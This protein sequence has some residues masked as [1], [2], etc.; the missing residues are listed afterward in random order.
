[1]TNRKGTWPYITE[2]I[3]QEDRGFL[4]PCWV[5]TGGLNEKGYGCARFRDFDSTRVHRVVYELKV[6]PI[7]DGLVIDHLCR[8]RACC[9][10]SHL[11]VVTTAENNRRALAYRPPG[12]RWGGSPK[13]SHCMSGHPLSGDN[14]YVS[15]K[16][17]RRCRACQG[18]RR[19][20]PLK[21]TA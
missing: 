13:R 19:R 5:W 6:G 1:M 9:N 10:P 21:R 7:P 16:G 12:V 18:V 15:P 4:T 2:R 11:E 3:S 8:V 17:A 20:Q 14:L